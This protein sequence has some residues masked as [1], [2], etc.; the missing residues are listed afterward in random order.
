[1]TG[2]FLP[3]MMALWLR[4]YGCPTHVAQPVFLRFQ[5]GSQSSDSSDSAKEALEHWES[6]HRLAT[7]GDLQQAAAELQLAVN[8]AP[9][10]A[11]YVYTLGVILAQQGKLEEATGYFEQ[12][13][14]LDPGDLAIRQKLAAAEW[15]VGKLRDA[16][17]NLQFI[18]KKKPNDKDARLILGMVLENKGEYGEAAKLLAAVQDRIMLHPESIA[19]LLHCYYETSKLAQAHDVE[20]SL[21]KGSSETQ[22]IFMGAT[23]AEE[24]GDYEFAERMLMAV[25]DSYPTRSEVDYYLARV[26]YH[27]GHYSEAADILQTLVSRGNQKS[28]YL[29]L[30]AWCLAKQKEMPEAVRTFH[31]AIDLDPQR[32]SNYVD[33][34]TVLMDAGLLQASLEVANKAVEVDPSSHTGY[35][36]RGQVQMQQHD[37]TAA[38]DSY[39]K[40]VDLNSERSDSLLDLANAEAA[41]GQFEKAA[42]ILEAS[43]K[44]Y[45]KD[46]QIYYQYAVIILHHSSIENTNHTKATALLQAA[47]T[48]DDSIAG[49]HCELGNILF[50]QGR[51]ASALTELQRAAKLNP[52][53]GNTH[54]ALWLVLRKL[55]RTRQAEDELQIFR[56]LKAEEHDTLK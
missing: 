39:A 18:L 56:R 30:L 40:A 52:S 14:K 31:R 11:L 3:L 48:L 24:S 45:P 22:S 29:N 53:D 51:F 36:I 15:Q 37:Y 34:A 2:Y 6:G 4:A 38:V 46:A 5:Q 49:A 20:N 33:L 1:M 54:Y 17:K 16:E 42:S 32:G 55:G 12:A 47:L 43:I 28:K 7:N 10:K 21:L 41:S 9:R 44:E 35:R 23:V 19:A 13:V 8:L 26:R 27:I 50:E 25:R